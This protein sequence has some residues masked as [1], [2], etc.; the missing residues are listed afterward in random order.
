MITQSVAR[1]TCSQLQLLDLEDTDVSDLSGDVLIK[2]IESGKTKIDIRIS[3]QP[4]N[5]SQQ[6]RL[7]FSKAFAKVRQSTLSIETVNNTYV[8]TYAYI[9]IHADIL[10]NS[11]RQT[12]RQRDRQRDIYD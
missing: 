3:R 7:K 11:D 1:A 12:Y 9:Y 10:T 4:K 5:M 6:V 8:R 2:L